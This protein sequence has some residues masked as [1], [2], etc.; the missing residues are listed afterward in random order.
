MQVDSSRC[1]L[2]IGGS[3]AVGSAVVAELSRAGVPSVLTYCRS[4]ATAERLA[5]EFHCGTQRVD[6]EETN[7]LVE[8][9]KRLEKTDRLPDVVIHCAATSSVLSLADISPGEWQRVQTVNAYS[10]LAACQ[11]FAPGMRRRGGGDIVFVGALDRTQSLPAPAHFA[12]SQGMLSALAMALGKE[13]GNGNI[14]VNMVALGPLEQGLSREIAPEL[15]KDYTSFS[16]LRRLGTAK[17]AARAIV[18]LALENRYINGKVL[19][20]NGGI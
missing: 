12:A 1:A 16:A 17:E 7:A 2:V 6:L 4:Q 5:E 20:I 10:A 18:W 8:L 3:G 14:R 13:L 11:R 19:P 9:E 15:L